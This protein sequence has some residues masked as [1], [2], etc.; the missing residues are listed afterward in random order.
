MAKDV[1]P[2]WPEIPGHLCCPLRH[3][4]RQSPGEDCGQRSV[5]ELQP[6]DT[7]GATE[8]RVDEKTLLGLQGTKPCHICGTV[9]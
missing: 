7:G 4:E 1:F 9:F 8:L 3:L 6:K 2:R 5:T